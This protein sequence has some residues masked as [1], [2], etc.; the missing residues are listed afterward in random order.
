MVEGKWAQRKN[1]VEDAGDGVWRDGARGKDMR[2][3]QNYLV[4]SVPSNEITVSELKEYAKDASI[5]VEFDG[6]TAHVIKR[7]Y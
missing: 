6:E 4:Q 2:K 5:E 1:S 3:P 7:V